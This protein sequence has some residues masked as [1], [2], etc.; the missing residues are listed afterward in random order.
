VSLITR[1]SPPV[2]SP[3][4]DPSAPAPT[5]EIRDLISWMSLVDPSADVDLFQSLGNLQNALRCL[6]AAPAA[7][8]VSD[9]YDRR[10]SD[11]DAS[12]LGICLTQPMIRARTICPDAHFSLITDLL[13]LLASP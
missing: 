1:N 12:S 13:A 4:D 5:H 10:R 7:P 6:N 3:I 11:A 9:E 8:A 2:A